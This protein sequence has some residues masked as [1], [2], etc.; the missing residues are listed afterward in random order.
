MV[1]RMQPGSVVVD[2]AADSG[3][4]CALTRPGEQVVHQGVTVYGMHRPA[5]E[6]ARHASEL[7]ARNIARLLQLMLRSTDGVAELAPDWSDDIL[8]ACC[9]T[10]DGEIHHPQPPAAAPPTDRSGD[11]P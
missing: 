5:S 7:L 1:E 4:N 11:A 8:A 3:G 9:V 10:R 6:L 2:L